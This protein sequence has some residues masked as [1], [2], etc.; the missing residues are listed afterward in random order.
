MKLIAKITTSVLIASATVSCLATINI[1]GAGSSFV[2]PILSRWTSDYQKKTSVQ[3][4]F[5]PIG[6]GG[7][8]NQIS[9][10]TVDFA[11]TDIPL[12]N[13][14]LNK[15]GLIQFPIIVGGIV[16]AINV[17]GISSGQ[18]NLNGQ[19]VADIFSGNI[20]YWDAP[21]IKK[22]NPSLALPH[23]RI[24][25]VHRADGSGTTYNFTSYLANASNWKYGADAVVQW[26]TGIGAKGNAGVAT[27]VK[28]IPGAIGYV[29]YAYALDSDL[30]WTKLINKNNQSLSPS[31]ENF[32]SAAANANWQPSKNFYMMLN[33]EPG[34]K[35]W[36]MTASTFILM[37]KKEFTEGHNKALTDFF[38]WVYENG[39]LMA[40]QLNYVP[41]PP[42]VFHKISSY[43]RKQ[44]S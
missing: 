27:Y 19:T 37:P 10:K 30:T 39:D 33:N 9:N 22:I 8:I 4:N 29:E 34:A 26:P 2:Y 1:T 44:L 15:L 41:I 3:I 28:Q 5:Q 23:Q 11:A 16:L 20:T 31:I 35:S 13:E 42:T 7:G 40:R 32:Q 12:S 38:T 18:L 24:T 14:K 25:I 17:Q 36:P 43:W 6:S 21:P